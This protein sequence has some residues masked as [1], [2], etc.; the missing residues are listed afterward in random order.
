MGYVGID[1]RDQALEFQMRSVEDDVVA[2]GQIPPSVA[3]L[4]ELFTTLEAH[5]YTPPGRVP[6]MVEALT[7]PGFD[8]APHLQQAKAP[9]IDF[10][11]RSL[12]MLNAELR[13]RDDEIHHAFEQLT[14]ATGVKSLPGIGKVL[15]PALLACVG[16]DK[17][18]LADVGKARALF[19]TAPVTKSSANG[20][21]RAV[22]FRWGCGKFAR[23]TVQ[24]YAEKSLRTCAGAHAF[25]PRQRGKGHKH[26]QALRELAHKWLKIIL[27]LQRT[28]PPYQE[29]IFVNSQ[30]RHQLKPVRSQP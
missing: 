17:T 20:K 5:G 29:H 14:E 21:Y 3:G 18:R 13:R 23:R 25:Y 16:R 7:R 27:A 2:E 28:G 24:L 11:A 15:G 4:A 26:H 22:H 19:G 10:L 9:R 30:R 1:W 6:E 12:R 8:V